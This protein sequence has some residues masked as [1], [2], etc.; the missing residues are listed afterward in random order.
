MAEQLK[1]ATTSGADPPAAVR[2][3][4]IASVADSLRRRTAAAGAALSAIAE[5]A[6]ADIAPMV[7]RAATSVRDCADRLAT[8]GGVKMGS[9]LFSDPVFRGTAVEPDWPAD[10]PG[11]SQPPPEE[12]GPP[13]L[14]E[15]LLSRSALTTLPDPEPPL[16]DDVLDRGTVALLYGM[17]GYRQ[18]LHC[19]GLGRQRGHSTTVASAD[20]RGVPGSVR[21]GRGRVWPQGAPTGLGVGLAEDHPPPTAPSMCSLGQST[22][23][24]TAT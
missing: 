14:A 3:Y 20:D 19:I 1:A 10:D 5:G 12:H 24:T 18:E 21:G 4:A 15:L 22:S 6:E 9:E 17:W 2:Q 13:A 11:P 23:P 16:I 8:C 7:E